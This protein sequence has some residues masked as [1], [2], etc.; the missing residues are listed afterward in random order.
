MSDAKF[1]T[2][3]SSGLANKARVAMSRNMFDNNMLGS[4]NLAF[5]VSLSIASFIFNTNGS[6]LFNHWA[7]YPAS[8]ADAVS[9]LSKSKSSS[10]CSFTIL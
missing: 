4:L 6:F 3:S 7:T 1:A 9:A 2:L 10:S 5:C 8:F